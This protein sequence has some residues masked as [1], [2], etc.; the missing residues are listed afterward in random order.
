[1]LSVGVMGTSGRIRAGGEA[2]S[3]VATGSRTSGYTGF[4]TYAGFD[5]SVVS[6]QTG[7]GVGTYWGEKFDL[8]EAIAGVA[9]AE[10]SLRLVEGFSLA[11]RLDY[12]LG[13]DSSNIIG[14]LGIKWAPE[15]LAGVF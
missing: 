13:R 4:V 2:L 5:V 3:L 11:A 1:M 6:L 14:T 9:H 12:L 8:T 15:A 7:L 10:L